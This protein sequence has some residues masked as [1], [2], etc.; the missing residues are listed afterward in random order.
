VVAKARE[1]GLDP[2][3]ACSIVGVGVHPE[4]LEE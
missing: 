1:L 3:V 4:D 2:I